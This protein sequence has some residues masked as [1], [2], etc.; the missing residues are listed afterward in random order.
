MAKVLIYNR[1][2]QLDVDEAP[3][4]GDTF[5]VFRGNGPR[6]GDYMGTAFVVSLDEDGNPVLEISLGGGRNNG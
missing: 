4:V 3:K 2:I 1:A 6:E 5:E